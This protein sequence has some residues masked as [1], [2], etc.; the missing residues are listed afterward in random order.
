MRGPT[1]SL[2]SCAMRRSSFHEPGPERRVV[3][4]PLEDSDEARV[5]PGL[6]LRADVGHVLEHEEDLEGLVP[7]SV[8]SVG[9]DLAHRLHG[10]VGL[11]HDL[12]D[13]LGE[14]LLDPF[15]C[16]RGVRRVLEPLLLLLRLRERAEELAEDRPRRR[17]PELRLGLRE[18]LAERGVLLLRVLERFLQ[19]FRSG[20]PFVL[21]AVSAG[22]GLVST[23]V[24]VVAE[25]G[26]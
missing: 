19:C 26:V 5:V 10:G 2:S 18:S 9:E 22:G 15:E 17:R 23:G 6:R 12:H 14:L 25:S 4:L 13:L 11:G 16:L 1:A 3:A 8:A 24:F 7:L 20:S 21:P